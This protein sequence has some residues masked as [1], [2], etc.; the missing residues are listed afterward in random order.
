MAKHPA[1]RVA[2]EAFPPR[3]WTLGG[4]RSPFL[5]HPGSSFS[6]DPWGGG[7]RTSVLASGGGHLDVQ[8]LAA[9]VE[10]HFNQGL[11]DSGGSGPNHVSEDAVVVGC[12]GGGFLIDDGSGRDWLRGRPATE[13]IEGHGRGCGHRSPNRVGQA[14]LKIQQD[15]G[16][17]GEDSRVRGSEQDK[18][19]EREHEPGGR[20]QHVLLPSPCELAMGFKRELIHF[21]QRRRQVKSHTSP[22]NSRQRLAPARQ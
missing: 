1:K 7:G 9:R 16:A 15:R 6:S 8:R 18:H 21:V 4:G 11:P 10:V 2:S 5:G 12:N 3:P 13:Q 17:L 19:Q 14:P 20:S 22:S